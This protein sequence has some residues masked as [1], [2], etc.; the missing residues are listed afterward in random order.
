[1]A[2]YVARSRLCRLHFEKPPARVSDMCRE[3]RRPGGDGLTK[4]AGW[5]SRIWKL[6]HV[7]RVGSDKWWQVSRKH[8]PRDFRMGS[9]FKDILRP[10]R[11]DY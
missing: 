10:V 5:T 9:R 7:L 8:R 3:V 11:A 1:M 4:T 2:W 6:G